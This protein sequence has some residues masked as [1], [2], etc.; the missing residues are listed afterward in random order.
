MFDTAAY[1]ERIDFQEPATPSAAMLR[2]LSLA[3]LLTVPFENLDIHLGRPIVLDERRLFDKI[4]HQRRGGFCY[5]LNGLFAA[6][7]RELGFGVTRLAAQY[8]RPDGR[9]APEMDHLVLL[10]RA[11]DSDAPLLVDVGAG[12]DSLSDPLRALST[13]EQPQPGTGLSVRLVAE[14]DE[15][16]VHRREPGA[17]WEPRYRFSWRA[18]ALAEFE[19]GCHFHQT[20]PESEFPR[21]R[22]CTLL[23]SSGRV[24]LSERRL[25]TTV[26]SVRTEE[27]LPDEPAV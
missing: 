15:F 6:L 19:P 11:V 13:A 4:V 10:V 7:L 27:E 3:H 26:D 12:D 22:I 5:E 2:S 14:G 20:S 16:R 9:P 18:R 25:I 24:T 1:L 23:T 8:P 17:S 21:K